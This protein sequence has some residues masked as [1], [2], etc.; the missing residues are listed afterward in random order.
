MKNYILLFFLFTST[1]LSSQTFKMIF[2]ITEDDV[3][4]PNTLKY[5]IIVTD[6]NID[7]TYHYIAPSNY[8]ML[9]EYAHIYKIT[10]SGYNTSEYSIYFINNGPPKNYLMN[11][12]IPLHY[13]RSLTVKKFIYYI[14][15]KSRY[16]IDPL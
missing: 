8:I 6:Y 11:L 3:V 13:E 1:L 7:T 16:F 9:F 14:E 15:Q 12:I 5:N 4:F 10:I 2:K